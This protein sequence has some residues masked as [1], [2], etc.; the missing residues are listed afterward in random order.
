MTSV[1]VLCKDRLCNIRSC[2]IIGKNGI[3]SLGYGSI[4]IA[5]GDPFLIIGSRGCDRKIIVFIAV[6]FGIYA[7]ERNGLNGKNISN[8]CFLRPSGIDFT[9]GNIFNIIFIFDIIVF[10]AGVRWWSIMDDYIFGGWSSKTAF[11]TRRLTGKE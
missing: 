4:N 5:S 11:V 3:Y 2:Q 1:T 7:I 8:Q 9:G 10:G 6:P